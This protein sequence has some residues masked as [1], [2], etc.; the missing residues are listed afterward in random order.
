MKCRIQLKRIVISI[1]FIFSIGLLSGCSSDVNYSPPAGS[2]ETAITHYS[3]G[4]III[5]GKSYEVDTM[6]LPG[7]GIQ[8]WRMHTNHSIQP[9]DIGSID[10][11]TGKTVIIGTGASEGS[12]VKKES[13][14]LIR[15]MGIELH[16]LNTYEAVRLFNKLPKKSLAAF[17][18]INC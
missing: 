1:T 4:K 11:V 18:H 2:S 14:D 6:I 15:S 17:F 12:G 16:M 3:F 7:K 13:V 5:D 8:R 9:V 10:G